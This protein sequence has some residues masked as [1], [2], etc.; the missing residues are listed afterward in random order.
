MK[1]PSFQFKTRT[2]LQLGLLS[3]LT[4]VSIWIGW[5]LY[6]DLRRIILEGFD[7]KLTAPSVVT[8]A[9]IDVEEH[10]WLAEQRNVRGLAF[11]PAE[12]VFFALADFGGITKLVRLSPENGQI[13]E[14]GLPLNPAVVDL[15]YDKAQRVLIG[16]TAA[17]GALVR[18]DPTTGSGWKLPNSPRGGLEIVTAGEEGIW[19]RADEAGE[20]RLW[21][22]GK[23]R[24]T[25][26]LPVP[27]KYEALRLV[28]MAT[29]GDSLLW[30]DN[31]HQVLMRQNIE[32]GTIRK[33][34]WAG[35]LPLAP[36]WGFDSRRERWVGAA[37]KLR[38]LD[39]AEATEIPDP[40][41]SAYGRGDSEEYRRL[42]DPLI[43]IHAR[44][45]LSY[46]YTQI[47]E[48]PD[49]IRY[50]ADTPEGGTHSLLL[51][52]DVLPASEVAGVTRLK[53]EGS[54]HFTDLEQWEQWGW[55]KAAFAPI[56]DKD[57][58]VVAMSGTDFNASVIEHSLRRALLAVFIIG[59]LTLVV[60]SGWSLIVSRWLQR[61]IEDLKSGALDLAAGDF[62][63]LKVTGS[64]EVK[65]LT[66]MFNQASVMME[67]SVRN[68]TDEVNL[69]LKRRD[70]AEVQRVFVDSI[71]PQR[72]LEND[73]GVR[74]ELPCAGGGGAV[75]LPDGRRLVWWEIPKV[76]NDD[77]NLLRR[78]G[79]VVGRVATRFSSLSSSQES[80]KRWPDSLRAVLALDAKNRIATAWTRNSAESLELS[81]DF[82]QIT[83]GFPEGG[84][85]LVLSHYEWQ[86]ESPQ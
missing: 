77:G 28:G 62:H 67:K 57:G 4:A 65:A 78:A 53:A 61:P 76:A 51:S 66:A 50:I 56:F 71:A 68:L 27:P 43:R 60:A 33:V 24:D 35:E 14:H 1:R 37:E 85:T 7:R 75:A 26:R 41:V 29:T 73:P 55:L 9:F 23:L 31:S 52:E 30:I 34:S 45:G 83:V 8:A 22:Q 38:W 32:D 13:P 69:L 11:A 48:P 15:V 3:A 46:L 81:R 72:V 63:T 84:P 2:W 47:V 86:E 5:G 21:Q 19:F 79:G 74:V 40:F 25:P 54:L 80:P 82:E 18:I 59:G 16:L 44:L 17:E 58:R 6:D 36:V 70:R 49:R 10:Q 12:D 39:L 64:T 20:V 42:L